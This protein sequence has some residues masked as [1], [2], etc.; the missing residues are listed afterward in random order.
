MTES[1][2]LLKILKIIILSALVILMGAI[3]VGCAEST[4]N[5]TAPSNEDNENGQQSNLSEEEIVLKYAHVVPETHATH[6]A[7]VEFKEE[8]EKMSDGRLKIE[9]YPNGQLYPS[10]REGIEATILGNLDM[11]LIGAPALA[12]FDPRFMVL[13]L[14]YLFDSKEQAFE[15]LDGDLGTELNE[16]MAEIGLTNLGWGDN[17]YK[18]MGSSKGPIY[19]VDDFDGLKVRVMENQLYQDTFTELGAIAEPHAFGELYSALQQG[20]FDAADQPIHLMWSNKFHEVLPHYTLTEHVYA[21]APAIINSD[22][23]NELP[24]DLRQILVEAGDK[25]FNNSYRK[26]ADQQEIEKLE[27]LKED[28]LNV[29]EL[30]PEQKNK[31]KEAVLPIYDKYEDQIGKELIELARSYSK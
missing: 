10:E 29:Y 25:V 30:T 24:E 28:G 22:V 1:K 6:L 4:G 23:F 21:S 20:V 26:L 31:I 11:M 17:G 18:N 9:I 13:D 27:E 5:D 3:V 19:S 7:S 12:G 15:A 2:G 14:P 8:V 16:V